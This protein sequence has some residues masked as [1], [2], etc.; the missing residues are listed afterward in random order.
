MT[1]ERHP[2]EPGG[3]REPLACPFAAGNTPMAT[4]PQGNPAYPGERGQIKW[5][6]DTPP[7]SR[8]GRA[9]TRAHASPERP[10]RRYVTHRIRAITGAKPSC[11]P[12]NGREQP[13][14]TPRHS[15]A[16]SSGMSYASAETGPSET[17]R[18][19]AWPGTAK[20]LAIETSSTASSR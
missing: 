1:R 2:T 18:C 15:P 20:C 16:E 8:C 5:G 19:D 13:G 6:L 14:S 9:A 12:D 10:G 17:A 7:Y 11:R 4:I 3:C